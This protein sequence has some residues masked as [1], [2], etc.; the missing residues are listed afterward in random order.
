LSD[1]PRLEGV[2]LWL[3]LLLAYLAIPIDLVPDFIPVVGYSDDAI[4]VAARA[5]S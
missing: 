3:W 1:R 4:I 5:T 2:R